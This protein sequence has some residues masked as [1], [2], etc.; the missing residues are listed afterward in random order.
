MRTVILLQTLILAS[1]VNASAQNKP[2]GLIAVSFS[3]DDTPAHCDGLRVELRLNG[4]SIK[5]KLAGQR[6]EIPDAF[7]GPATKWND[8]QRVDISLT[9][10]GHTFAFPNQYPA[11][12]REGDWQLG[13]TQPLYAVKHYGYSHEFD[14]GAWLGYLIFD[15][16][17]GVITFSS[18]PDPPA[19]MSDALRK[20]Q[21]NASA[22]RGR[23]IAYVLAVFNVEYQKNRDLLLS[24]LHSC[25]ARPKE[26]SEDDFLPMLP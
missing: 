13:I 26:S 8:D 10:G 19:Q 15:G 1:I 7:Q 18:Q 6:F 14:H 5:P 21:P 24:S 12:V 9:C 11:F 4:K 3:I 2:G 22:E 16:E 23:D 20:E 25:L 17:P